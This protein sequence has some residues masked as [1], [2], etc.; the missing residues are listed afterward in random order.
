MSRRALSL[1][2]CLLTLAASRGSA[3][4]QC[5][6][7]FGDQMVLQQGM[8]TPIWGRAAVGEAVV[9]QFQ[10][11]VESAVATDGKWVVYLDP[12]RPGGPDNLVI[13]G[14]GNTLIYREVMV[15]DVWLCS[16]QS[17][18]AYRVE[19][20]RHASEAIAGAGRYPI[21]LLS[22]PKDH[23]QLPRT[24]Q[25]LAWQPASA[26][27]VARFSGVGWYFGEALA[28]SRNVP[29]GLIDASTGGTPIEAWMSRGAIESA[30]DSTALLL[31]QRA[32]ASW[33]QAVRRVRSEQ[34][35]YQQAAAAAAREGRPAPAPPFDETKRMPTVQ[36]NGL[37][38][39]L[40]PFALRGVLWYQGESNVERA[41]AYRNLLT[42]LIGDWRAGFG[43]PDLPFLIVQLPGYQA[44]GSPV[45]AWAEIREAQLL[46]S[47]FV[48]HTGLVVTSDLGET[49]NLHPRL[50]KPVGERLANAAR[51]IAYGELLPHAGPLYETMAVEASRVRLSF[52]DAAGGLRSSNGPL[53]GFAVAGAD[54][55]FYPAQ[56]VIQDGDVLVY[57]PDVDRPVAVRYGWGNVPRGNLT[58]GFG[59][60]ASPF[61]TDA[62]AR[63]TVMAER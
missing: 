55:F 16:G 5:A 2:G 62:Y 51:A 12:L 36:F 20:T 24:E 48:P 42:H 1:I 49:D 63:S 31:Y 4:V 8:P 47:L 44:P 40:Q 13:S 22:V 38:A 52:R 7:I 43:R 10:G 37:I 6:G 33:D 19:L 50:K 59:N 61:R 21:R 28:A 14:Q 27:T 58:D 25:R 57:S 32:M 39:P 18:M 35:A 30:N 23:A 34:S 3:V 29:I 54:G 46:T 56:A 53:A 9:V 15:G 17:N 26:E 60:P 11:Q 41:G 45:A